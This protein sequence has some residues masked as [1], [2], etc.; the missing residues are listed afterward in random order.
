ML[1]WKTISRDELLWIVKNHFNRTDGIQRMRCR[2][3]QG[4]VTM[5]VPEIEVAFIMQEEE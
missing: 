4:N 1:E 3:D 5:T 2:D